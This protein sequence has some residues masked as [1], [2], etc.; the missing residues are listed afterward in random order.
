MT[1]RFDAMVA[2]L[3]RQT[4][5]FAAS[6]LNE[7]N[8]PFPPYDIYYLKPNGDKNGE[9]VLEIAVAGY[10]VEDIDISV[11]NGVLAVTG[12]SSSVKE[13][14]PDRG[15]AGTYYHKG[16]A[17]RAFSLGFT[18][19]HGLTVSSANLADGMLVIR[20]SKPTADT[21]K[22]RID[23]PVV[24]KVTVEPVEAVKFPESITKAELEA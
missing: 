16:I 12:K 20:M 21:T 10:S 14:L 1:E 3:L 6:Q 17:R 7:L 15:D 8:P 9:Y 13:S 19:G 5:G 24:S 11:T 23:S 4:V 18:L 22:I 2:N